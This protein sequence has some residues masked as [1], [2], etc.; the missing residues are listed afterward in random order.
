MPELRRDPIVGRWVIISTE[1][2]RRPTDLAARP[3]EHG[4]G[5]CVFCA[6]QESRTPDEVWALRPDGSAPNTPGWLARVVPNKFP[7]LRIEGELEPSGEGLY[8]RMNGVGAHEVVIEAPEHDARIEELPSSH[9]GAVLRAFRERIADLSRDHRLEYAMVFKNSGDLAGASLEHTHSQLI[10]TPIVP[11]M[12]GEELHGGLQHFRI[13]QRCIWCDIIRQERQ[14]G[15]R[16]VLEHEGYIA[17]APFAPRFPFETWI[18]PVEHRSAYE[19]T[20]GGE[21]PSLASI[22]SQVLGRMRRTLGEPP[23]N[24]MLHSAPLR[25]RALDHFHWHLEIIP[26]LTRVAGFEWGTGF[27][28]NPTPPEEA[29]RYLREDRSRG[30]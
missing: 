24:L 5:P 23:Y 7:A 2:A 19:A 6:G 20:A 15:S 30:A 4:R 21:F 16:M 14:E 9:L 26:K 29:A 3:R 17:I 13:K 18:M 10:A 11:M 27:F 12:V 28:I 8:D 22:L 25:S 1:R